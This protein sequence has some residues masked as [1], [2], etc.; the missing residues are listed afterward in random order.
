MPNIQFLHNIEFSHC[1]SKF[2]LRSKKES[3]SQYQE[4]LKLI[5]DYQCKDIGYLNDNNPHELIVSVINHNFISLNTLEITLTEQSNYAKKFFYLAINKFFVYS[6]FDQINYY[7]EDDYDYNLI[8]FCANV[9]TNFKLI[10]YRYCEND[11]GTL[12]NFVHPVT[13]MLFE[14]HD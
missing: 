8:K 4:L 5:K 10:R 9:L 2:S 6:N 7:S 14:R 13:T 12:G 11:N 3:L 1:L